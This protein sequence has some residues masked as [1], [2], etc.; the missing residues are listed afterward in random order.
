MVYRL[1]RKRNLPVL[2]LRIPRPNLEPDR[3]AL[4]SKRLANLILQEAPT[5][6]QV[7]DGAIP[8]TQASVHLTKLNDAA[9]QTPAQAR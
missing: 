9:T 7:N 8:E 1:T 3:R 2:L 4:E 5:D 6:A